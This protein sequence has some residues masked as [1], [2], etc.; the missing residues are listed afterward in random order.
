I[1]E[2]LLTQSG[3][4]SAE[5]TELLSSL[6]IPPTGSKSYAYED[7]S[8]VTVSKDYINHQWTFASIVPI[9]TLVQPIQ[10]LSSI[11]F[12]SAFLLIVGTI[13]YSYYVSKREYQPVYE[14]MKEIANGENE[15]KK[16]STNAT[17]YL[18]NQWL[19]LQEEKKLLVA[20]SKE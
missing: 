4:P 5:L 17:E 14:L 6:D 15:W 16:S 18:K 19:E 10:A 2:K 8:V 11:L 13:L 9:S 3:P 1:D 20:K 12:V 7:Y